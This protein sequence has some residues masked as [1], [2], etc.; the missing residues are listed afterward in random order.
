[1]ELTGKVALVTGGASG[2]GRAIAAGLARG[3]ASVAVA[4]LVTVPAGG[5]ADELLDGKPSLSLQV[6]VSSEPATAAMAAEVESELGGIDL[7]V[8]DAAYFAD[9]DYRSFEEIPLEEWRH[10]FDVNVMGTWLCTKAVVPAMRRRGGGAIVNIASATVFKGTPRLL[11]YVSSKGAV[12]AMTRSLANELG[13]DGIRVNAIAPGFTESDGVMRRAEFYS[14]QRQLA[15]R[16]RALQR[17]EVPEDL[18]GAA[19]FLCGPGAGFI[20]GQTLV[21]DGGSAFH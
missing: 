7:L 14:A 19:R 6:D 8:N 18:A 5:S 1:V 16:T 9:L 21:V 11:H 15:V 12:V 4:D 10:V 2:I 13:P 3:G 17:A 20:T